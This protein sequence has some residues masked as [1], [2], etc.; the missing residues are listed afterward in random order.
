MSAH[1][2]VESTVTSRLEQR[3]D[4]RRWYALAVMLLPT[5]LITLNTYMIQVA[6]PS[7]QNS[8]HASF[9]E[10]QLIVAGYS[11]G[12]AMALIVSGKLGDMY[13]RK[14]LLVIGVITFT[15][16]A[17]LGGLAS[18]PTILIMIRIM[19]GLAAALIQPQVLSLMQT[20]FLPQ[21]K[22][23]AFGIYGAVIGVGFAFGLLLGG[24]LVNLNVFELGWRTVFF[25][26]VPFGLL[27]LLCLPILPETQGDRQQHIDWLGAVLLIT[28]LFM[29]IFPLSE[30]QK[31]GWPLWTWVS[32]LLALPVM[33]VFAAVENRKR[34][35][36]RL[37][38]ID[39]TI[40]RLR[41]FSVGLFTVSVI[42]LNMFSFFFVLSYYVQFGL[43]WDVQATG[44]VFLPLG[45]GYFLTSL[46]SSRIVRKWGLRVL[47]IGALLMAIGN[48]SLIWSIH[49]DASHMLHVRNIVVLLV[50]GF[51]LGMVTTPLFSVVLG[52]VPEEAAGTGSGLLTTCTYLANSFGVALIGIL[53]SS[54][55]GRS[56]VE[57][58]LTDYVRAFSVSLGASGGL[59]LAG[60]V[61]LCFL[62][63]HRR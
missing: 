4:S 1:S 6:L 38:L 29:L 56:L 12:L 42:Y 50:Y 24:M 20:S 60:W 28:G 18:D 49:I 19:Q 16:T 53:F 45:I 2:T 13:G 34:Q 11:L 15:V 26:N 3:V 27:V 31:Q 21:E 55:L 36:G 22:A 23:L 44:M 25:F 57:A 58:Q 10:A 17:A 51:G 8:L 14:R 5:L 41:P 40:F 62:P 61:C 63:Q 46:V 39:L 43:H 35:L 33:N 30:G 47:K 52:A 32:M 54:M 48:F 9:S 7:M 59:A 37:P